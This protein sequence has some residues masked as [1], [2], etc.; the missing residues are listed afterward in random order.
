PVFS[1]A[2]VADGATVVSIG[3][4]AENRRE[5][6]RETVLEAQLV[7]VDDREV[8]FEHAGPIIDALSQGILEEHDVVSLG[9]ILSG[10]SNGRTNRSEQVYYNSVG[11]GAQDAAAANVILERAQAAGVGKRVEA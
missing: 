4:Y 1:A 3:S 7:V 8:A 11:I 6:P 10:R 5:V 2:D 9:E